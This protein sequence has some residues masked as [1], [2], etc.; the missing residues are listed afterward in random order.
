MRAVALRHE[1]ATASSVEVRLACCRVLQ[2]EARQTSER[3]SC[4]D[5][6]ST[7]HNGEADEPQLRLDG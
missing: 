7:S 6:A 5:P 3:C 2:E 4:M 1:G